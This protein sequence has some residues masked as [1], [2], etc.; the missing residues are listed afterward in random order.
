M[1]C[2]ASPRSTIHFPQEIIDNVIDHLHQD[3]STLKSCSLVCRAWDPSSSWHLFEVLHPRHRYKQDK[4]GRWRIA[5]RMKFATFIQ[6][7]SPRICRAVRRLEMEPRSVSVPLVCNDVS[8]LEVILDLLPSLQVLQF[9]NCLPLLGKG[10]D[11]VHDPTRS[12][13]EVG[14]YYD[15]Q[16]FS[17]A[18]HFQVLDLLTMFRHVHFLRVHFFPRAPLP[19]EHPTTTRR[20]RKLAVDSLEIAWKAVNGSFNEFMSEIRTQIDFFRLEGLALHDCP[21]PDLRLDKLLPTRPSL[22]SMSYPVSPT[23]VPKS[24]LANL[25]TLA[26][27]GLLRDPPCVDWPLIMRDLETLDPTHLRDVEIILKVWDDFSEQAFGDMLPFRRVVELDWTPLKRI[28]ESHATS[29]TFTMRLQLESVFDVPGSLA[30]DLPRCEREFRDLVNVILGAD[31]GK[32]LGV[33]ASLH[34]ALRRW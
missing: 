28:L 25:H 1:D 31:V 4:R 19:T 17:R 5:V 11:N 16:A 22:R 10:V 20:L 32:M 26:I 27:S 18:F 7:L 23:P 8:E 30:Q 24:L 9:Y 15:S 21:A 14:V 12:L 34:P 29:I 3:K 2:M 13:R 6:L 33:N